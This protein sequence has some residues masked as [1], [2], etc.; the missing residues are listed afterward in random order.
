MNIV[1]KFFQSI[2]AGSISYVIF[3]AAIDHKVGEDAFQAIMLILAS[4][5]FALEALTYMIE[6][7]TLILERFARSRREMR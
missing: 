2:G 1:L 5:L 6:F 3:K 4:I 7:A